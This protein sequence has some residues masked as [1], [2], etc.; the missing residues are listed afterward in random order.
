MTALEAYKRRT[1][2]MAVERERKLQVAPLGP[3]RYG[4]LYWCVVRYWA[5][6]NG[7]ADGNVYFYAD[8]VFVEDGILVAWSAYPRGGSRR[9]PVIAFPPGQWVHFFAAS[10]LTGEPLV[11]DNR[12]KADKKPKK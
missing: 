4:R 6:L 9:V 3:K 1:L 10:S 11:V 2:E 12:I 8:E 5:A 7:Q